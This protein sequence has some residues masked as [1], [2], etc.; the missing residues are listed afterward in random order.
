MDEGVNGIFVLFR[1]GNTVRIRREGEVLTD[2]LMER[3]VIEGVVVGYR[4]EWTVPFVD[5]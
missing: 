5:I 2:D 3:Q 1:G 4:P